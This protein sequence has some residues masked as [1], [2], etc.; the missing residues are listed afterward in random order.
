MDA[1]RVTRYS[2]QQQQQQQEKEKVNEEGSGADE[3]QVASVKWPENGVITLEW[4]RELGKTLDFASRNLLPTQ[5]PLVLPVP[6]I[7]S[8][9][10]AAHKVSHPNSLLLKIRVYR[11]QARFVFLRVR[12]DSRMNLGFLWRKSFL[13]SHVWSLRTSL[14]RQFRVCCFKSFVS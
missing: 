10:L 7:D 12:C 6:V 13:Q 4:V 11:L 3:L 5:L 14:H 2:V 8:L 1:R 9:L